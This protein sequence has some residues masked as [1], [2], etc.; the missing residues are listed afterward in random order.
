M[1]FNV[2]SATQGYLKGEEGGVRKWARVVR[3][4]RQGQ[5]NLDYLDAECFGSV[6][7]SNLFHL[8]FS[9]IR[10]V[11]W[12]CSDPINQKISV[13]VE[14]RSKNTQKVKKNAFYSD[15]TI[16]DA[17]FKEF[18]FFKA[19]NNTKTNK[20]LIFL[21]PVGFLQKEV[22]RFCIVYSF[23]KE[24]FLKNLHYVLFCLIKKH[25]FFRKQAV[26]S[27]SDFSFW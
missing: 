23:E 18:L 27:V 1:D 20:S 24:D 12:W 17:N 6:T 16:H 26:N 3:Q 25:S 5:S 11:M 2:L 4:P 13:S 19:T 7:V 10:S 22:I 21:S 8:E 14:R 9:L 15:K